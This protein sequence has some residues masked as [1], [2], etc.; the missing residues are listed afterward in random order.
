MASSIPY[1]PSVGPLD[2]SWQAFLHRDLL[3]ESASCLAE[4]RAKTPDE[5]V[6]IE[7]GL[8]CFSKKTICKDVPRPSDQKTKEVFERVVY[9]AIR[10]AAKGMIEDRQFK[11]QNRAPLHAML[12]KIS[13]KKTSTPMDILEVNGAKNLVSMEDKEFSSLKNEIQLLT[14]WSAAPSRI[15]TDALGPI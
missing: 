2:T 13:E 12:K 1:E 15:F 5:K 4:E 14:E 8:T 11:L 9:E 10:Q 7:L 6:A 3:Q